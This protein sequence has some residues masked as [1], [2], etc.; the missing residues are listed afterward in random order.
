MVSHRTNHG[1]PHCA[2]LCC[3]ALRSRGPAQVPC[4]AL[5]ARLLRL[6]T[7]ATPLLIVQGAS[8]QP[9]LRCL[10]PP[11]HHFD[12]SDGRLN[13][14]CDSLEL[15]PSARSDC[16][17][18]DDKP[19][20][21]QASTGQHS[22]VTTRPHYHTT[23]SHLLLR[24]TVPLLPRYAFL[25]ASLFAFGFPPTRRVQ[26]ESIFPPRAHSFMSS[27]PP[28][29]RVSSPP[30]PLPPSLPPTHPQTGQS[31]RPHPFP[32]P[33]HSNSTVQ[34][35][36][37]RNSPHSFALFLICR[38]HILLSSRRLQQSRTPRRNLR[39][40]LATISLFG[41]RPAFLRALSPSPSRPDRG[42]TSQR[43]LANVVFPNKKREPKGSDV[44]Y[45]AL[46][47]ISQVF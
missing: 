39:D 8:L 6:Q 25:L 15:L 44:R 29:S 32:P 34:G 7:P 20:P 26:A 28:P 41:Q 46:S 9:P 31:V 19:R 22:T 37:K 2:A 18:T 21:G 4:P 42:R 27:V 45:S 43:A 3:A 40:T 47:I 13:F 17:W 14:T 33:F 23:T 24:S 16:H 1:S 30:Q 35:R 36:K 5:P 38:R 11:I 10:A 12:F